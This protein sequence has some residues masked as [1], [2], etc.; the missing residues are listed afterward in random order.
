MLCHTEVCIMVNTKLVCQI[1]Q[2][3]REPNPVESRV[4]E[5]SHPVKDGEI[6]EQIRGFSLAPTYS[7]KQLREMKRRRIKNNL[8][9]QRDSRRVMSAY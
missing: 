5:Y 2:L 6:T 1:V 9:S 3:A 8:D 7:S 4:E